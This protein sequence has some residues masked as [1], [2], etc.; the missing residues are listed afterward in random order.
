M[1]PLMFSSLFR[2]TSSFLFCVP[3]SACGGVFGTKE[4]TAESA[5]E[6]EGEAG[7]WLEGTTSSCVFCSS[8][9]CCCCC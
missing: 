3:I 2:F 1:V 7:S 9:C 8:C 6:G 4:R 5:D